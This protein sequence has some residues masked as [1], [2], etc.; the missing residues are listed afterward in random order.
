MATHETIREITGFEAKLFRRPATTRDQCWRRLSPGLLHHP[1]GCGFL[2]WK[3]R[4]T[5]EVVSG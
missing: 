1:M 4:G 2:D 3:E 5:E